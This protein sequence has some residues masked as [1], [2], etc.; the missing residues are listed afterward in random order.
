MLLIFIPQ[1]TPRHEYVFSHIFGYLGIDFKLTSAAEAFKLSKIP[2]FSYSASPLS[3][4]MFFASC[5][6]LEKDNVE[7][8]TPNL[9]EN[10]SGKTLFAHSINQ[11]SFTFDIFSAVFFMISRYEEYL[12]FKPDE[13]GRFEAKESIAYKNDFLY[14][15]V[16][17]LWILQLTDLL[18]MKFPDLK[19]NHHQYN[20]T[21]T[22]DIDI[23]WSYKHKGF[24]R[25]LGGFLRDVIH[26]NINGCFSRILVLTGLKSDPYD[27]F[28]YQFKLEDKYDLKSVHFFH[29]GTYGKFDKNIP[30]E[31]KHIKLLL[32]KISEK[33]ILGIHPSFRSANNPELLKQEIRRLQK[34]SGKKIVAARQHFIKIQFPFTYRNFTDSGITDDYSMGFATDIG[35]RAGTSNPFLFFDVL[36]NKTTQLKIHPFVLMEGV[37]KYYKNIPA[38]DIINYCAPMIQ[39]IKKTNGTF[40]SLWHNESLGNAGKWKGWRNIYEDMIELA[41]NNRL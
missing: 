33:S 9:G 39:T 11:S 5:G 23:A 37:F 36:Q 41:K 16:V 2:K 13:Y 17:D 32:G 40:V 14:T 34:A 19:L 30:P 26:L 28:D 7:D 38:Q 31:N 21:P 3:D 4:E 27:S 25:N 35:F 29:P 8:I 10:E 1:I 22:Y 20:F 18:K 6:F 24:R 15:P 12:P